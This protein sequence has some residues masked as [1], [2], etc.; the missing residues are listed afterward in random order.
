MRSGIAS[1][2]AIAQASAAAAMRSP[3]SSGPVAGRGD[4]RERQVEAAHVVDLPR[5][6][7]R[8]PVRLLGLGGAIAIDV[9]HAQ[10]AQQLDP[11]GV[12]ALVQGDGL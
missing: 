12:V 11:L 8:T 9:G 7:D 3:S 4:R 10:T 2:S 5:Q 6:L 1:S